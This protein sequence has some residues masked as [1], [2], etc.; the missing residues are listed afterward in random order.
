MR[1]L[2]ILMCGCLFATCDAVVVENKNGIV[3]VD[4]WGCTTKSNPFKRDRRPS[5]NDIKPTWME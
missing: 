3:K 2:L 5:M 4:K 1:S